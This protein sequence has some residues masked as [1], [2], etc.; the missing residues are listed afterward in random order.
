MPILRWLGVIVLALGIA[1]FFVAIPH[2][3]THGIKAGDINVGVQTQHNERVSPAISALLIAGG[4]G[5]MIAGG[6]GRH[7][8]R[9]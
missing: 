5:L 1:S 8:A 7:S 6:V 9:P 3:E 4:I 2:R